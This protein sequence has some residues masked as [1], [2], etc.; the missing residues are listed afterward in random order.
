MSTNLQRSLSLPGAVALTV[1]FVVGGSIFVLIPTLAG[2]TGPSLYLAY[3]LSA[4]PAVFAAL[5]LI[6]LGGALPVTG[7]NYIAVTR[8]ISPMAGFSISLA[9]VVAM[10][11]TNCLVAWGFAEYLVAYIPQLPKMAIAVGVILIFALVNC[12]GIKTFEKVQVVM[13]VIFMLAMLLFGIVGMFNIQPELQEPFFPKGLGGFFTV[14]AVASF[15]WAGVIAI[16]EVAGEVKNPKRN[17][18]LTIIISMVI[19][20]LLYML[21]T[22]VFTGTLLWEKSAEIGSA[23]VLEAAGQFLPKWGVGFIALGA[24]LA[25][26]TTINSMILMGAREVLVWSH[27]LVVPS[28]FQRISPR[29]NTPITTIFLITVLSVIGVLFAADIEKY[30]LMVIFALMVI[31]TLGATAT[32]RMPK[33]APE[34]YEKS[35]VKFN[36]FWRWFTWIGCVVFFFGVFAFGILADYQ[37]FLVFLGIWLV[38]VV[39]WHARKAYLAK[40]GISLAEKL[41]EITRERLDELE[42]ADANS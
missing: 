11:S 13:L 4:I 36:T 28:F 33:V 26:A 14:V 41:K 27:D 10:V 30:A 1:G 35:Q 7:A 40:N 2:M 23:A 22:Y 3:L 5:Y 18:P 16:V 31:Q 15:S 20:G 37:T 8:W 21:Q 25:M 19:I 32:L 6:Q 12:L 38:S 42:G 29:Y 17:V 24:L 9:V 34:I 39:Y